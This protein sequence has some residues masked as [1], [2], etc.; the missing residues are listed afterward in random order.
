MSFASYDSVFGT[1]HHCLVGEFCARDRDQHVAHL[2]QAI[3]TDSPYRISA[4]CWYEYDMMYRSG[5]QMS[6]DCYDEM[7]DTL[8]YCDFIRENGWTEDVCEDTQLNI[9]CIQSGAS[10]GVCSSQRRLVRVPADGEL[11]ATMLMEDALVEEKSF[12]WSPLALG[13]GVSCLAGFALLKVLRK[14]AP[15][16][17]QGTY[18]KVQV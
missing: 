6:A 8:I 11:Q 10:F 13:A 2:M 7:R 4:Q 9:D 18:T 3:S 15:Q 12:D 1:E 17:D 5:T 14:K 16:D